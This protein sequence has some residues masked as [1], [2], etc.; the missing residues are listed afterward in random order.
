[1]SKIMDDDEDYEARG[2]VRQGW[3]T[4]FCGEL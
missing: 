3:I 2:C 1:M 4:L